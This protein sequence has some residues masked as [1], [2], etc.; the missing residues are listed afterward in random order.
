MRQNNFET[1]KSIAKT[2]YPYPKLEMPSQH[3]N[4]GGPDQLKIRTDPQY[5]RD[6]YPDMAYWKNCKVVRRDIDIGHSISKSKETELH[7]KN[8]EEEGVLVRFDVEFMHDNI[9]HETGY[10]IVEIMPHWAPLGAQRFLEMV[11]SEFFDNC[12]FF[13]ALKNFMAQFGIGPDPKSSAYW[14]ARPI[15][16]DPVRVSNERGY[17]SFAMAGKNTRSSQIFINF[18]KNSYLDKEGFAPFARVVEGM[19]VIDKIYTGYGEGGNGKGTDG[20]GPKQGLINQ[21]GEKYLEEVF[22][23]LTIIRKVRILK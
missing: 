19:D 11:E 17:L 6:K 10:F 12:R 5:L 23:K 16:D 15:P 14:R 21:K 1:L 20:R 18:V 9:E 22:P 7:Q 3:R 4:G 2:G 8:A 13:R